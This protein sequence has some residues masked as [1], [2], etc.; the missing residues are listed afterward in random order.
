MKKFV[1]IILSCVMMLSIFIPAATAEETIKVG[2]IGVLTGRGSQYGEGVKKGIEVYVDLINEQGGI[3]GVPVK[4]IYEDSQ[5]DASKGVLAAQKLIG[6][7]GCVAILG[8]V[9]TPVC[10]A[11]A[12]YCNDE[13]IPMITASGTDYE[14]TT[15][16]PSVFRTC[17]LDP[18][19]ATV[20]A[21]YIAAQG[22][23]KVAALYDQGNPYSKG[24]YDAFKAECENQ[25]V[26]ILAT[27]SGSGDDVDFKAQLTNI[28]NAVPEAVFLPYYGEAAALILTQANEIGLDVKYY[29]GDGISNIV[30][31]ITDKSLLTNMVYTDHFSNSETNEQALTFLAAYRKKFGQEP[32]ISFIATAY[33]AARVLFDAMGKVEDPSDYEAVTAA[34]KATDLECVTGRITFDEHNDP[35]KSVFFTTFNAEGK[36]IFIESFAPAQ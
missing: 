26:E 27:E 3:N 5:G 31:A 22:I 6:L 34:I 2:F 8:P 11:V 21:Q 17:F 16:R 7:D 30:K 4:V 14:I 29:G 23:T 24:L 13:G 9:I 32:D 18:F 35:I 28:K 15:G 19:Q 36:Q 20:I 25:G 33:D 12:E 10:K 1:A